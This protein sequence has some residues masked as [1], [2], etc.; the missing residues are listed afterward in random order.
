MENYL[1]RPIARA[2]NPFT[3]K[4]GIPR[5]GVLCGKIPTRIVFEKEFRSPE[6]LRGLEGFSHLWL[7]WAFSESVTE[8]FRP[9]VRPP[10]LGGN[11]RMGVFATRS[12]FRPN[13]IG[14]SCVKLERVNPDGSLTV[15]GADVMNGTPILDV[16]PY[17]PYADAVPEASAGFVPP[18][19][20]TRLQ[21]EDPAR[22]LEGFGELGPALKEILASDP[23]PGYQQ[24]PGRVYGLGFDGKEVHF[25]VEKGTLVLLKD[26][27]L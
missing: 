1:M 9:T 19:E 18:P 12:P 22:V 27:G 14:L 10:K 6:A 11:V 15:T 4:F 7:I 23:R 5:Q 21:V 3:D 16:K 2:E 8:T 20:T 13:P 26:E 17:V 24:I 25:T